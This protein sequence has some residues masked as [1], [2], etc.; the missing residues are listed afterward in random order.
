MTTE[1]EFNHNQTQVVVAEPKKLVKNDPFPCPRCQRILYITIERSPANN[2]LT[3]DIMWRVMISDKPIEEELENNNN[4]NKNNKIENGKTYKL[5]SGE[6]AGSEYWVEDLWYKMPGNKTWV[7]NINRI[8]CLEFG[9]RSAKE[10][11]YDPVEHDKIYYGKIGMFGKL[12]HASQIGEE[13]VK[14]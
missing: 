14:K 5:I 12:I 11:G 8:G 1:C 9:M 7:E 6:F 3:S 10:G 2:L 13:V 4:N